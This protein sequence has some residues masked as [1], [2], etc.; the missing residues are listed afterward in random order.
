[1]LDRYERFTNNAILRAIE[2]KEFADVALFAS[3]TRALRDL[4]KSLA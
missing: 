2:E 3:V 4:R 1:V